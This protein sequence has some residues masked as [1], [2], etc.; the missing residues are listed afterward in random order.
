MTHLFDHRLE[1][2]VMVATTGS[3]TAAAQALYISQ[4]AVS[5][6]IRSLEM[7]LRLDLVVRQGKNVQLTSAARELVAYLRHQ[8]V[9]H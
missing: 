8:Q 6:Q 2:L 5:Q 3:F 9:H 4:P 7:D 1:T